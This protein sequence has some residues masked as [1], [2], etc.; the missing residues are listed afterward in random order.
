MLTAATHDGTFHADDVFAFAILL[1][2][3][4][5]A[6]TLSRSRHAAD[7]DAAQVVFD[8]GGRYDP[9]QGRYDHHMRERPL[10]ANGEPY[11]SAGLIWRDYGQEAVA[12]LLPGAEPA[13]V[14][15]VWSRL[16]RGLL[17]DIDLMDNGA[18]EP[19][20][21]HFSTLLESWNPTFAEAGSDE[22]AAYRQAVAVAGAVLERGCAQ[23]FAA[24][25]ARDAV[26]L[27]ATQA[28]DPRIIVLETRLPWEDAVF[29]LA[30]ERALYVVRPAGKGWTVS[31][32]PPALGSFAQRHPLPAARGGLRDDELAA[33]CGVPDAT[34]C[35]GALF[36][37]GAHSRDGA[38]ALARAALGGS[39]SEPFHAR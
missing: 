22:N 15:G 30:L 2:A 12:R 34:F 21:G 14:E 5:G 31:A 8:V 17:R 4:G 29:E 38:L 19:H 25:A 10:R 18:M 1:A 16:D 26:A 6:V 28:E 32:V 35:H 24:I 33:V 27:A 20:P 9:A 37:C 39:E 11:S 23:A 7:W 13:Q 36:V 3:T